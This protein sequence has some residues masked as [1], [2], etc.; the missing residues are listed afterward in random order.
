M[1]DEIELGREFFARLRAIDV[2]I[3][4]RA[5]MERAGYARA[6]FTAATTRASRAAEC[7]PLTERRL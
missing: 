5:A 4:E 3:V 1:F 6:R 7:W 2:A